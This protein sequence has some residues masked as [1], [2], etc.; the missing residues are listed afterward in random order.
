MAIQQRQPSLDEL[1]ELAEAYGV[2]ENELFVSACHRYVDQVALID[3]MQREID[4]TGLLV[5]HV[6]VRG[7]KNLEPHPLTVQLP[8]YIDTANKTMTLM[9]DL[10]RQLGTKPAP[11]SRLQEIMLD[12]ED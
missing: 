5:E 2:R 3:R 7:G 4:E 8:K 11:P 1:L 9:L 12:P 6:N 10:I